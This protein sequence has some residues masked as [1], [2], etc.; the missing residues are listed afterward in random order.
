MKKQTK[1]AIIAGSI[2]VVVG[3][4]AIL[5][6][7]LIESFA[8]RTMVVT[9]EPGT[10]TSG[11]QNVSTQENQA[12]APTVPA[13]NFTVLDTTGKEVSLHSL[14][15][16]PIIL[17][18]WASWCPPCKQEMPDFE[19][20]YKNYGADIQ[21]MMVNMTDGG[22]ETIATAEEYI[23]SQGFSFPVYFDTNQE[24]A[25]EYGVSAIPTTYF[26]NAQGNIVAY[27]AGA[28]TAQHLEQGIS[29]I[30]GQ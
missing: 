12:E 19:A 13:P 28:I 11:A 8:P 30:Q 24:A 7:K 5:Y 16:K 18:F 29:M 2:L 17:N 15:G 9:E 25:I 23:A 26:V 10:V 27:A 6:E 22:R 3:A 21:F 14:V 1:V 4:A 20:A